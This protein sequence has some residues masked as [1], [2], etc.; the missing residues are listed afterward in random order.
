[1]VLSLGLIAISAFANNRWSTR[2]AAPSSRYGVTVTNTTDWLVYGEAVYIQ[3][4]PRGSF[5]TTEKFS[6]SAG[7]EK[8]FDL[9]Y[10]SPIMIRSNNRNIRSGWFRVNISSPCRSN[11]ISIIQRGNRLVG[12]CV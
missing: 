7:R 1:M 2:L 11:N 6:I 5:R 8:F 4:S 12:Q 3:Q 10:Q 9:R